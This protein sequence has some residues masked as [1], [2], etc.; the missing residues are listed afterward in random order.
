MSLELA[1][2]PRPKA[3]ALS[4][5][6]LVAALGLMNKNLAIGTRFSVAFQQSDRCKRVVIANMCVG[7]EF[8][9]MSAGVFVA[10]GTLPSGRHE[11]IAVGIST[12]MDELLNV[13]NIVRALSHQLV[14][15]CIQIMLEYF[16][17]IDL[18]D[19][20]LYLRIDVGNEPV[21]RDSSLCSGK[22][23]LF[24]REE[25]I[26][27][28]LGEIAREKGLGKTETLNLRLCEGSIT[29]HALG[30]GDAVATEES[31][32]AVSASTL[33]TSVERARNRFAIGSIERVKTD[34]AGH[35]CYR[36][37]I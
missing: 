19:D 15:G 6:H 17:L 9:A 36:I 13:F 18:S 37:R 28:V 3:L 10:S 20:I 11:A 25:N 24:L 7:L 26:L 34:G 1:S 12:S 2:I 22:H 8:P 16:E 5:K 14:F 29:K 32:I 4:A 31:F 30:H 35:I 27:L 21:M 23:G 33:G